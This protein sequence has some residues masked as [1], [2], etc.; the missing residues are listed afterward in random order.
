MLLQQ[1]S[2]DSGVLCPKNIQKAL[3]VSLMGFLLNRTVK[4]LQIKQV[5]IKL[6]LCSRS[7]G[8]KGGDYHHPIPMG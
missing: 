8:R 5:L 3:I 4:L 1:P 2:V 7:R 6:S